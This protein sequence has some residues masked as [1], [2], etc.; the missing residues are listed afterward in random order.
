MR[1]RLFKNRTSCLLL[2]CS[3]LVGIPFT[4]S[5]QAPQAM[6]EVD[7]VISE[8]L[9]QTVPVIGRFV[10][11]QKGSVASQI[12]APVKEVLVSV[13]DRVRAG[14]VL[15]LLDA[16][17]FKQSHILQ[18]A[19]HEGMR[20]ALKTAEL[21]LSLSRQELAR[22]ERLKESAAFP[23]ARYNDKIKNVARELSKV[24]EAKAALLEARANLKL[25]QLD[26]ED[27]EIRAPYNGVIVQT[28]T[29]SGDYVN[30]GFT[31]ISLIND[32]DMEI[33]ADVPSLRI[34][35]LALGRVVSFTLL[36]NTSFDAVVRAVVPVENTLTR[37]RAVRFTPA[38]SDAYNGKLAA[39]ETATVHI[40]VGRAREVLSVH[41][42]GVMPSAKGQIIYVVQDG[43]AVPH[44]VQLGEPIG[45]R[46]EVLSGLK[47]GDV[48]I[49][50]GN[51]RLYPNQPVRFEEAP[52][53]EN[54]PA[55]NQN[56]PD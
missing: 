5:A 4:A 37:T 10:A 30:S 56:Q 14:E 44:T 32:E 31:V 53:S 9:S 3:I 43:K 24:E 19:R 50:K 21:E 33:E 29:E 15:V 23:Q 22:L 40:P 51:E 17:R 54:T 13:G 11:I 6:V 12:S 25:A 45:G 20:N 8:P 28:H 36:D 46:F 7:P 18:A 35:A 49:V 2:A 55:S 41:K 38:L 26:L 34:K 48:V 52:D 1:A 27:T 42:D 39:G 47:R 16:L